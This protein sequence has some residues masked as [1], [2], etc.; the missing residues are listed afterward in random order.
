MDENLCQEL[1]ANLQ[2]EQT[3][4][5][6]LT[7]IKN[8]LISS[9]NSS[10]S[11][12]FLKSP[13]LLNCL[14]D[15][16][17]EQTLLACDILSI[18]MSNLAIDESSEVKNVIEKSL[19]HV[20]PKVQAFGLRE[21]RRI[22]HSSSD[23][24]VNETLILLVIACLASED[25]SVGTPSIELLRLMLPRFILLRSV[26]E[27]L[28]GLLGKGDVVRCRLYELIVRLAKQSEQLLAAVERFLQKAI[29]ELDGNDVLLQLNI[30][31]I[32]SELSEANHGMVYLENSG[33][34]DKLMSK[35]DRLE[36]DPLGTILIPG[37]MKFYGGVA[38]LH[39]AKV[40]ESFPKIIALLFEC[41]TSEDLSILPTAYDTLGCIAYP[42]EGKRQLHYKHGAALKKTL[43]HIST[44]VR[45]LPNDLKMR[46]L[47]CLQLMFANDS[48]MADNQISSILQS[49]Y[50]NLT[51]QDNLNFV[52]DYI[53]N[54]FPDMKRAALGLLKA[55]VGHRWGQTY[56]LNTGGFVEYLLDRKQEAD[57]DVVLDKYEVIRMLSMSSVFDEQTASDFRRYVSEGAFY[58]RG[59]TEVAIEGA[60]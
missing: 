23:T 43:H 42:C 20:N 3:R 16:N 22:L 4:K 18:C 39:P 55:I 24:F 33:V 14:E 10:I 46:L 12:S 34:F 58:V 1:L 59:I 30:L 25:S 53:R 49:W 50:D 26:L 36:E 27:N 7:E 40:Y 35:I 57:K 5:T 48:T 44:V 28:D 17:S 41:L 52:M 47:N 51:E 11:N 37:L 54:P 21:L 15:A 45:N 8:T 31:Q 13:E 56:L 29:L 6:A 38:A 60:S 9:N 19:S 32:L 2:L